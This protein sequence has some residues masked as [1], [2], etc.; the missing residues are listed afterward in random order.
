[1]KILG[2][3]ERGI[4]NSLIFNIGED[5]A[6]M[7]NFIKLINIDNL[8]EPLDYTILL[9]QS[10]SGFGDADLVIILEYKSYKTVL[11]IE[12]K[13]KTYNIK[14]WSLDKQYNKF[15]SRV[16]YNGYSSNLFYQLYLKHLMFSNKKNII[17]NNKATIHCGIRE[18]K[19][20]NNAIVWDAFNKIAECSHAYYVGL[21][22]ATKMEI[23]QFKEALDYN[24]HLLSWQKVETFCEENKLDKVKDIFK[25]NK[26]QIH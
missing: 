3:S 17:N 5:K 15:K 1:M 19:I 20:G 8:G 18:R 23:K 11:F 13:V 7:H 21:I 22:P 26:G 14:K 9:E 24:I 10:F 4:I 6:L 25:Y 2:Y 12:G 16:K